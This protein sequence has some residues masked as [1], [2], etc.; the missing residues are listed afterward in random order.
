MVE[1]LVV[2]KG[3]RENSMGFALQKDP[4]IEKVYIAPGNAGTYLI[5]KCVPLMG[6]GK[7]V[8]SSEKDEALVKRIEYD[9]KT[10]EK[11]AL[12]DEVLLF[13]L[14]KGIR[15]VWVGPEDCLSLGIVDKGL[16]MGV[17]CIIG[18]PR[19]CMRLEGSKCWQKDLMEKANVPIP[20][21]KNFYYPDGY[22]AA[23][24]YVDEMYNNGKNVVIKYDGY[25][26]GKGSIVCGSRDQAKWAVKAIMKDRRI[27]E[28][29]LD[30]DN[31]NI[32]I[33]EREEVLG[34]ESFY[35]LKNEKTMVPFGTACEDK[36][37]YDETSPDLRFFRKFVK[38]YCQ[39]MHKLGISSRQLD[40]ILPLT[41]NQNTGGM[42][43]V[44]QSPWMK[45][46][47]VEEVMDRIVKPTFRMYK[48]LTGQEWRGIAY[49][50]L[51]LVKE[52]EKIVRKVSEFN[53][54]DG[55]IETELRMPLLQT[56]LYDIGQAYLEDRMDEVDIR[57]KDA[58]TFG[59]TLVSGRLPRTYQE[60]YEDLESV[61]ENGI[62]YVKD[63][64][65]GYPWPH[66]TNQPIVGMDEVEDVH[67]FGS[68]ISLRNKSGNNLEFCTSGGRTM[69]LVG[70]G[71]TVKEAEEKVYRE[72][73]KISFKNKRYRRTHIDWTRSL[74]Q[75]G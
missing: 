66:L 70:E 10:I 64:N 4:R 53:G 12:I 1:I 43:G 67:I 17:D 51:L 60:D 25:A 16:E 55:D 2:G 7:K 37:A 3:G 30:P 8:M 6:L 69:V 21:H 34:E 73:A 65:L 54:R 9:V 47:D 50:G 33:D 56:S 52:D 31:G 38:S 18:A 48:E 57:W 71:K 26:E 42:V 19:A 28:L 45:E 68:G 24:E 22:K 15:Q 44:A 72:Q 49:F 11:V 35:V 39:S 5:P 40:N 29:L 23:I 20:K 59:L 14:E 63:Q 46:E 13:A 58:Y 62:G 61:S 75:I 74:P 41:I 32:E 36:K 27:G